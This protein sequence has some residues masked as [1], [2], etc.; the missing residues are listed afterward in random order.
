MLT[1]LRWSKSIALGT[2]NAVAKLAFF[3]ILLII[4]FSVIGM[5]KGDGLPDQIVLTIRHH[6]SP[7]L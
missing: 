6:S 1:F 7:R 5:L 4:V 3:I 2:L